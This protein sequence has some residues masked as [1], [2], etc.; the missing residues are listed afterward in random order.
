Q[1]FWDDVVKQFVAA[2][3]AATGK[4]QA[5]FAN[6]LSAPKASGYLD[7][8]RPDTG[9]VGGV[10]GLSPEQQ[11]LLDDQNKIV[12]QQKAATQQQSDASKQ[13]QDSAVQMDQTIKHDE[14]II[15]NFG[16]FVQQF[17]QAIGG[18]LQGM[19]GAVGGQVGLKQ[20]P[21]FPGDVRTESEWKPGEPQTHS[22]MFGATGLP[23]GLNTLAMSPDLMTSMFGSEMGAIGKFVN[24][25]DQAGNM[26]LNHQQIRDVSYKSPGVPNQ[27]TIELWGRP[28]MGWSKVQS[29]AFANQQ[30]GQYGSLQD[31][32]NQQKAL[33]ES[34]QGAP[35]TTPK[36]G[37]GGFDQITKATKANADA[38]KSLDEIIK[39]V[40]NSESAYGKDAKLIDEQVKAGQLSVSAGEQKKLADLKS[41]ITALE[42]QRT[43]IAAVANQQKTADNSALIEKAQQALDKL[44]AELKQYQE[45]LS[46]L[47]PGTYWQSFNQ[48]IQQAIN[49]W[50][51]LNDQIQNSGKE[52]V[53]TIQS[54]I[55]SGIM[56]LTSNTKNAKQAFEDMAKSI[57][58]SLE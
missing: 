9:R 37:T 28:D 38:M 33:R 43:Q 36:G 25:L 10:G 17:G 49:A 31:S 4:I 19:G 22:V 30:S 46:K 48:G 52:M 47:Q 16:A 32:I 7:M 27:N 35:D 20:V 57:L 2:I 23:M 53:N 15:N 34:Q 45:D 3:V 58:T 44:D 11:K 12:E 8:Q 42:Q 18:F 50:G 54:G 6:A 40:T 51:T 55:V 5:A 24:I 39:Q 1:A 13:G 21:P 29:D 14:Q 56:A 41:E 26:I